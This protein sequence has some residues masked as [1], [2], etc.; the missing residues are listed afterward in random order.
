MRFKC[1]LSLSRTL[2]FLQS[3]YHSPPKVLVWLMVLNVRALAR[4]S[5]LLCGYK[6]VN[7]CML[8]IENKETIIAYSLPNEMQFHF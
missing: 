6:H 7:L 8:P 2:I 3:R 1:P 5:N 4:V